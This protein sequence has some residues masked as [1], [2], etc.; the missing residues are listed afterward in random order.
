MVAFTSFQVIN[1]WHLMLETEKHLENLLA[2]V[3]ALTSMLLRKVGEQLQH[4]Q[5]ILI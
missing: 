3:I 2:R 1:G 5:V 4:E